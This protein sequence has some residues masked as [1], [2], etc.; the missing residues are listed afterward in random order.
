MAGV[1][2]TVTE[3]VLSTPGVVW[4]S[5]NPSI[6]ALGGGAV[7]TAVGLSEG[8]AEVTASYGGLSATIPVMVRA[9][10]N[11]LVIADFHIL[12]EPLGSS[13]WAY[14]PKL[15]LASTSQRPATAILGWQITI[16]GTDAVHGCR[17]NV[18]LSP[19]VM[20]ELFGE[21][22]GDYAYSFGLLAGPVPPEVRAQVWIKV[23]TADGGIVVVRDS[24]AVVRATQPPAYYGAITPQL[25]LLPYW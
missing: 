7:A 12:E 24:G 25:C 6:V 16:P 1:Y 20:F 8:S 17:S 11:P 3:G 22:Y 9:S 14:A 2:P 15:R 21:A 5:S 18:T 13:A 23:Q 4:K 19:G 10:A